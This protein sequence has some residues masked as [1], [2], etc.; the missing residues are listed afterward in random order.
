MLNVTYKD[1]LPSNIKNVFQYEEDKERNL[2][3]VKD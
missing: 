1:A 2:F 3:G